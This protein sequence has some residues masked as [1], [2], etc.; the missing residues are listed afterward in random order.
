MDGFRS[1]EETDS[2]TKQ[3]HQVMGNV[4]HHLIQIQTVLK[5]M[6]PPDS[7]GPPL[8][9]SLVSLSNMPDEILC[10]IGSFLD[11]QS[12]T[13]CRQLNR[14][15]MILFSSDKVGWSARCHELW[16][17]KIHIDSKAVALLKSTCYVSHHALAMHAYRLSCQD[18][19]F[20]QHIRLEELCFDVQ[21]QKGTIWNF[22]FKEAAGPD[23]TLTDPWYAGQEARQLVFLRDGTVKQVNVMNVA[24]QS[25]STAIELLEPFFDTSHAGGFEIHWKFIERPL[26]LPKGVQGTYLR[27]NVAGRDLPTYVVQRSPNG[28]WGFL[29]ENCWGVFASFELPPKRGPRT[30]GGVMFTR[31]Y[32]RPEPGTRRRH[33]ERSEEEVAASQRACKRRRVGAEPDSLL[34]EDSSLPITNDWQWREALLYN[35]GASSLPDGDAENS[36][37]G[38]GQIF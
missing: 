2:R 36:D 25:G 10:T 29:L 23:W 11:V 5:R 27:L 30:M 32:R 21:N 12:L 26:D 4:E 33:S 13:I 37:L 38:F 15:Y 31:M 14:N 1:R 7:M 9:E 17:R 20:R 8:E 18:A 34:L 35:L 28:N 3:P 22:R 6:V 24:N 19:H 16:A